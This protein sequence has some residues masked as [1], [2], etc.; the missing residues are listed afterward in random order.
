MLTKQYPEKRKD[1]IDLLSE[2]STNTSKYLN[3]YISGLGSLT[4][5]FIMDP[6]GKIYLFYVKG[7]EN[8]TFLRKVHRQ[9]WNRYVTNSI[10][11]L[12]YLYHRA[13]EAKEEINGM[14]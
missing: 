2:V 14:D 11:Y 6:H 7:W 1:I 10:H 4:I 12:Y 13:L 9:S 8:K 5:D 3:Y